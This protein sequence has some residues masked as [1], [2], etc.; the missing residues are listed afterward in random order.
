MVI[1]KSQTG[2]LPALISN[3]QT[4]GSSDAYCGTGCQSVFGTCNGKPI[5]TTTT[6][7][8]TSTSVSTTTSSPTGTTLADCLLVKNVPISLISSP[9]FAQLA[10][11]YNLRLAYTPAVIVFPTTPQ[12][13]SDAVVCAGRNG[14]KV[15]AKSGG[16]SY[17]SFSSGGQNG[18]MVID[19]ES[20]QDINVN[21]NGVATVGAGVR[22]GNLALGIYN[23]AQR[24]LP[25]GTCPGVGI[26][27]HFTH[28]GYGYD[29]RLWGLALD[30]IV[31]LDVVLANGS[32]VYASSTAYPDIYWALRGAAESF[33]IVT[34]FYLQTQPAPSNVVYWAFTLPNMYTSS[35][36]LTNAFLHIQDFALNA[37]VIDRNIGFGVHLDGQTFSVSG[38]Y[39]GTLNHFTSVIQPELLRGL[40]MP[41]VQDVRSL[42]WIAS[43]E[44]LAGG[45]LS[46]PLTGYNAH[47]DFFAKSLVDPESGPLTPAALTSYFDYIIAHGVN[48][49]SASSLHLLLII[50]FSNTP[51]QPWFSI[52][53]IY[54]GPDSQINT[55]D[56]SFA[57]YS[58]RSALWVFQHYGFT[59]ATSPPFPPTIIPFVNGLNDAVTTAQPQTDF[60][61]Y[62]NYVDPTLSAAQAHAEYYGDA[63]YNRLLA[64]KKVVD[65]GLV[66]YNPQAIGA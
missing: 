58:D 65:P 62:L 40:P 14:V 48:P 9:N 59:G 35:A 29:S 50:I 55:K 18:V 53:N 54:G 7:S 36:A 5:T 23:Q 16:H 46:E 30:T 37:S 60:T 20:F 51:P 17:A 45:T 32:F 13:I 26:G 21:S 42:S 44:Q 2:Q 41:S 10:Q 1:G 38:T 52:I 4:S 34:K 6:S 25:H 22:L 12:H 15:Q 3:K 64:L 27:G 61:G 33:G 47:D 24:A 31:G 8:S 56:A 11:P 66:F 28:G 43:L 63:V 49:P 57:A 39:I 19:L